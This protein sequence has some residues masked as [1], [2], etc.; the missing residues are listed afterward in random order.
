MGP[1]D[2]PHDCT[3]GDGTPISDDDVGEMRRCVAGCTTS[4]PWRRGD[5]LL[6][7]NVLVAH[8]RRPFRGPRRILV[9]LFA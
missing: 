9:S 1:D 4:F 7:D 2:F 6:I 3:W 8:G 5:V